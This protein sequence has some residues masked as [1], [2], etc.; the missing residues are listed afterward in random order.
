[1]L[2]KNKFAVIVAGGSGS[3]MNSPVPKQF[4]L[5]E[6]KPILVHTIERFLE[7]ELTKL[8]VVLPAK[9]IPYWELQVVPNYASLQK[10]LKSNQLQITEGGDT[11]YQSV[12]NGL[13]AL[14]T[15]KGVVAIHD[16]VRPFISNTLI[17]ESFIIASE[18]GSAVLAVD[19]K[20]SVRILQSNG[21]NQHIDRNKVKLIQ[22][23]QTFDLEQI[24]AAFS[25]GEQAHFTDDASVYEFSGYDVTL[26]EGSY[27]NIKITTPEDIF[28]A[29]DILRK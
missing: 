25:M 15:T 24:T 10:G 20:D 26:I 13:K 2:L 17:E 12:H 19:T 23:P 3:R 4:M 22:T 9:D 29:Q 14:N 6:N 16:G 11:R 1:M 5:L 28:I 7:C 21:K 8:V 18:K 27:E